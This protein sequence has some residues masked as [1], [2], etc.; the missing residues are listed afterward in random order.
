MLF[1]LLYT[2]LML[3]TSARLRV[4]GCLKNEA[5]CILLQDEI[6]FCILEGNKGYTN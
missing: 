5:F 6:I 3:F 2:I 1:P 4:K